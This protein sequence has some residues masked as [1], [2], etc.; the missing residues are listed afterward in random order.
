MYANNENEKSSNLWKIPNFF[1]KSKTIVSGKILEN[2][3]IDKNI[4][5]SRNWNLNLSNFEI[6]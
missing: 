3:V 1:L 2:T 6:K 5:D 4:F